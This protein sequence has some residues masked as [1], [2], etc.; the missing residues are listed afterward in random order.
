[1]TG[2]IHLVV[3]LLKRINLVKEQ[4]DR[5]TKYKQS[6]YSYSYR[7]RVNKKDAPASAAAAAA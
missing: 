6:Y 3:T 1:M 5:Q 4:T 2:Y 7:R